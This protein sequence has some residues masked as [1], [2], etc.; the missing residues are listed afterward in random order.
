MRVS[1]RFWFFILV[2]IGAA[3]ILIPQI[4]L[5]SNQPVV[6]NQTAVP[7]LPRL[8]PEKVDEGKVLYAQYCAE[9]HG[10]D[11]KG[12]PTWKQS[13]ADGSFPPPPH[14]SSGHTWHHPD[15]LLLDIVKNGGDPVYN[16]KMPAFGDKLSDEEIISILEFIKSKWGTEE[17]EFQWWI[18]ARPDW[19]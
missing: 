18:T 9:C 19:E 8:D 6:I 17:R 13:L 1:W 11:L 16:S 4:A 5:Q 2:L 7:P 10:A 3:A 14:D 12:S 15:E